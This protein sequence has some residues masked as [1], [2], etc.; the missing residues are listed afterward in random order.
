LAEVIAEIEAAARDRAAKEA[1]LQVADEILADQQA[2]EQAEAE[3]SHWKQIQRIARNERA[4]RSARDMLSISRPPSGRE[5]RTQPRTAVDSAAT[6]ILVKTGARLKGRIL[7]LS[8][9]GCRIRS[10]Q[11]FSLGI[12]TRVETEFRF[13]GLPFLL[14]GVIQA[15]HDPFTLGIR[16]LD[17]SQRKREQVEQLVAELAENA[18]ALNRH[19]APGECPIENIG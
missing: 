3:E 11:R 9:G 12:Y 7:D 18:E 14:A 2:R 10:E 4:A 5:R 13:G 15:V 19:P 1:A 8:V 16:F 6:L 17:V